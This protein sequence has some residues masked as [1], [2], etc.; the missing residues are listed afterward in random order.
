MK[1]L[2][3]LPI[4]IAVSLSAACTEAEKPSASNAVNATAAKPEPAP[5]KPKTKPAIPYPTAPR[6]S[7][8]EAKADFDAGTAVFVD[9]H[10]PSSFENERIAGAV[11]VPSDDWEAHLNKIPK[12]K[13][14]IAYCS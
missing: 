6:I 3:L 10:S 5:A 14:I 13:K 9:T 12:G 11:N 4:C 8:A 2:Y 7:L 1:M